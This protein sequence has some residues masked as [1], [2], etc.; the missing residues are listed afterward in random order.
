[1]FFPS[2]KM[3]PWLNQALDAAYRRHE[4][5]SGNVANADTPDYQARDI[6]FTGYLQAELDGAGH[7]GPNP[8]L[9]NPEF[10]GGAEASLDGNQVNIEQE[11]VRMSSNQMFY[12][13]ASE[14]T[15]RSLNGIRYAIDEG[16]Q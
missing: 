15:A 7:H 14:V 13:L 4:V 3:I 10:R 2:E 11:M 8:G 16:G 12:D 1:M 6:D 5:L 9:P